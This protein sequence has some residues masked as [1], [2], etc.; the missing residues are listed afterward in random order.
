V[1]DVPPDAAF[2]REDVHDGPEELLILAGGLHLAISGVTDDHYVSE[3]DRVRAETGTRH[4]P[5]AG[6]EGCRLLATYP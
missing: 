4:T 5:V 2:P 1:H 3:G 6:P